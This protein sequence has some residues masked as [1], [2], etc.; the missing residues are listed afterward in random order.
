MTPVH[1]ARA[2]ADLPHSSVFSNHH[3]YSQTVTLY[4]IRR[5]LCSKAWSRGSSPLVI[6]VSII[7]IIPTA[8]VDINHDVTQQISRTSNVLLF[9][10]SAGCDVRRCPVMSF[11]V[12]CVHGQLGAM[13][14]DAL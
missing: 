8:A 2:P 10:R 13:S 11:D 1:K 4:K 7:Y 9:S 5:S 3:L 12:C 14:D 6:S